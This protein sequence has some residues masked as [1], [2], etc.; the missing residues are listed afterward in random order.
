LKGIRKV[1]KKLLFLP[2]RVISFLAGFIFIASIPV[3]LTFNQKKMSIELHLNSFIGHFFTNLYGFIHF[4]EI[5]YLLK[6]L[7]NDE[8]HKYL[9]S[10]SLLSISLIFVSISGIVISSIIMILPGS[11]R[12]QFKRFIDFSTTIP[13][14][15]II[16]ILQYITIY[17]YKT[18]GIKLFRL[19]G[20]VNNEPYFEPLIIITFLPTLFLIQFLLKEFSNEEQKDYVSF[21]RAKGVPLGT[22]FIKH[23]FRNVFPLF[24]IHLR[25]IVWYLL[26][27][28]FVVINVFNMQG[29]F[30]IQKY[31][32][33][34]K[35]I[36]FI[37]ELMLFTI[38]II[39]SNIVAHIV[40]R[41]MKRKE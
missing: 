23:I 38:P 4:S 36:N 37:L 28:T 15:L 5:P 3:L 2:V 24:L 21:A 9:Y 32:H 13:E 17:V 6:Y 1:I 7:R 19:Y 35:G 29:I 30:G 39:I 16:F 12:N 40:T 11:F 8:L 20:G 33:R 14:L 26:T 27:N 22:I 10:M 41:S 31:M 34:E 18:Y 25:T